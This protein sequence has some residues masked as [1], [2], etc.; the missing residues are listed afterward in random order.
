MDNFRRVI[1]CVTANG[2]FVVVRFIARS[3]SKLRFGQFLSD[4]HVAPMGLSFAGDAVSINMP[5]L[6]GLALM[7]PRLFFYESRLRL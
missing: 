5:P 3:L 2:P 4:K 7:Y 1:S 6:R